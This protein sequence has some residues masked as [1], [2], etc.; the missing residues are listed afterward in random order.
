MSAVS[1]LLGP[2]RVPFLAL[3]IVCVA[4]GVATAWHAEGRVAWP[5][6]A[7]SLVAA[8]TAHV[9]VN[10]FNEYLDFRSG[11]DLHTQ[12]TPFSGGSGALPADPSAA[13]LALA[14]AVVSL[15]IVAAI[16][17]WLV[18]VRG[19]VLLPLGIA[20]VV[21]IVAYTSWITRN[22]YACLVAPGLGFGPLMVVGT[23]VA[24][25][26]RYD[27]AA[28]IAALVPFFLVSALLLLNQFP[29]VEADREAGRRHLPIVWGRPRAAR[30]FVALY[31]LAYLSLVAGVLAGALPWPCLLGLVTLTLAVPAAR[32]VL[33][34]PDDVKVL[35][36]A[37]GRNVMVNLATPAFV[38]T[39]L[40]VG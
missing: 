32:D 22:P 36:P 28:G 17:L 26:G 21:L 31:A 7:L 23:H 15:A 4:L 33:R 19:T 9:S 18:S 16:G 6:A 30:V 40:F 13:P 2:M 38:A 12:R 3:S 39:G 25:A 35:L 24:V 14:I 34:H 20:G 29:D 11:L 8:L 5:L 10:A 1:R 37:M 27:T